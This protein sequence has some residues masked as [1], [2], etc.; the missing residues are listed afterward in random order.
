MY[1]AKIY[2]SNG[3]T[4]NFP[5]L[6]TIHALRAN[7]DRE[8]VSPETFYVSDGLHYVFSSDT[9]IFSVPG[10]LLAYMAFTKIN[11]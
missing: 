3:T 4:I 9:Q 1:D 7:G 2:L 6:A 10:K 8:P 5:K 11:P